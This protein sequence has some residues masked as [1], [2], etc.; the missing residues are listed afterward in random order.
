MTASR[1]PLLDPTWRYVEKA[2]L[3]DFRAADWALLNAQRAP[4]YSDQQARQA[5]RLLAAS[6]EDPG[7]GYQVNNF[8]HCVQ[9]A[10][11]AMQ[12]GR[13]EE[14][15]VMALLHD[16]G[17]VACP[18]THGEFAAQLLAPYISDA[19]TWLLERHMYFQAIH[20]RELP[21]TDRY[22][23]DR[24]RGHPA[25][26]ATAEFVAKYDQNT[27]SPSLPEAPLA[28]FEPMVHRVFARTPRQR[29]LPP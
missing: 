3:D 12:D 4:Y 13:D 25:F 29:P 16:I 15:V 26:E 20:C 6:S 24:W 1:S 19:N 8:R 28:V 22:V 11:L 23:R 14:Y 9:A 10:T 7:F 17:F 5:L 27:I 2:T 18:S 21:G